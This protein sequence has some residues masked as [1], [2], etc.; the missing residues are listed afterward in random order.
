MLKY[1]ILAIMFVFSHVSLISAAT[2]P[3]ESAA[4]ELANKI[5]QQVAAGNLGAAF[6]EMKPYVVISESEFDSAALQ[7]K[8][9]RE[10]YGTRYGAA[11]SYEFIDS[12]KVGTSLLRLRYLEKTN[13]HAIPWVFYFFK[14]PEGWILNAFSWKDTFQEM[15]SE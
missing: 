10:Q 15:F 14:T 5:M 6:K 9:Q 3:D 4:K 7:S 12:K 1:L 13:R 8:A 11:V 2:V